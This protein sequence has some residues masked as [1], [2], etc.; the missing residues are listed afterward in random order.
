MQCGCNVIEPLLDGF[1]SSLRCF[2]EAPPRHFK[3]SL[4][5]DFENSQTLQ[6][7][8]NKPNFFHFENL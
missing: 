4:S 1:G 6:K 2:K 8:S 3:V 5:L 7:F